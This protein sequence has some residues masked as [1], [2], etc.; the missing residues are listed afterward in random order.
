MAGRKPLPTTLK[1]LKGN[2]GCRPLNE[3]EP[4]PT[5]IPSCPRHLSKTA[6][7]EW[8]RIAKELLACGLLTSVDRAALAGYCESWARYVEASEN[9][10]KF[11]TVIKSPNGYPILSPYVSICN[12]ALREMRAFLTEFGMTPA[13]RSRISVTPPQN[14]QADEWSYFDE[15][16]GDDASPPN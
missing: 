6:R 10:Q 7:I 16:E 2:P 3:N 5:G 12:T 1:K 8:R 9:V 4:Q 14:K 15:D 13:S 11:G